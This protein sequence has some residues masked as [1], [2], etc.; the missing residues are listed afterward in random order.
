MVAWLQRRGVSVGD[1]TGRIPLANLE[2]ELAITTDSQIEGTHFPA[3][4]DPWLAAQRLLRVNLSDLAAAAA[5][6]RWLTCNLN[7]DLNQFDWRRFFEGLLDDCAHYGAELI[8]GDCA[9]SATTVLSVTALGVV[10]PE[11]L[12]PARDAARSGDLVWVSGTLGEA[13]LGLELQRRGASLSRRGA[14]LP[15][16]VPRRLARAARRAVVR[17]RLPEP[18]IESGADLGLLAKNHHRPSSG[19]RVACIDISDG[20][21]KDLGRVCTASGVGA[22]IDLEALP[23]SPHAQ[24][25]AELLEVDLRALALGGGEDYVLLFTLPEGQQPPRSSHLI[26]TLHEGEA[27]ELHLGGR[28]LTREEA[29]R[30]PTGWDHLA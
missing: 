2:G 17:H 11:R 12:T 27:I 6:P 9:L 24:E 26:G 15:S 3:E 5:T 29:A 28:V 21:L 10:S 16:I 20:L 1:D 22:S 19:G 25:L 14:R 4:L 7:A 23:L 18:A 13:A 8:G 30:L